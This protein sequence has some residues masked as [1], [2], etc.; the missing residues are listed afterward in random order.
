MELGDVRNNGSMGDGSVRFN[1]LSEV[2]SSGAC[3]E[4]NSGASK[5]QSEVVW[6]PSEG[7]MSQ[8][9]R[10]FMS[11]QHIAGTLEERQRVCCVRVRERDEML[12]EYEEKSSKS[13]NRHFE[14]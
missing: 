1:P 5:S 12:V 13:E 9:D 10:A 6:V 4:G 7:R 2:E 8:S 14:S 11:L 3:D